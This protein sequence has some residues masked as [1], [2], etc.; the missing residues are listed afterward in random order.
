MLIDLSNVTDVIRTLIGEGIAASAAWAPNPAPSVEPFAPDVMAAE[1]LTWYLYGV[2]ENATVANRAGRVADQPLG[3]DLHYQLVAHG[4]ANQNVAAIRREQLLLGLAMK[5]L[6]DHPVLQSGL[7]VNG[8]DVFGSVGLSDDNLMSITLR[9]LEPDQAITWWT[10]SPSGPR[11]A[12]YYTVSVALLQEE[13]A[14][15]TGP[16]VLVR[17][18]FGFAGMAPH[19]VS[20]SS[21]HTLAAPGGTPTL[22]RSSPAQVLPGGTF[23]VNGYGFGTDTGVLIRAES[24]DDYRALAGASVRP[25][26]GIDVVTTGLD[27]V[28]DGRLVPPGVTRVR[29]VRR[30]ERLLADGSTRTFE[31]ESND[32]VITVVPAI[33][34]IV[35]GAPFTMT[36]GPFSGSGIDPA[37]IRLTVGPDELLLVAAAPA[38]GEFRVVDRSS[39][40]FVPLV[41]T[42]SGSA[43]RVRLIVNGAECL[44]TWYVA[45]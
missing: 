35:G 40:E 18:V 6:H 29:A 32:T 39:I 36:G 22:V 19:L 44:P 4:G 13:P 25:G 10:A 24:W 26:D 3:L 14:P 1:G 17:E 27:P 38:A 15:L 23:D 7:S 5:V 30:E 8:V 34:A 43:E 37:S 21:R 45:P 28:V 20:S 41:T 16:P 42:P 31:F 33:D 9:K 11:A 12:A 2:G